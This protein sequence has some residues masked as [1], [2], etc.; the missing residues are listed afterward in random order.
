[1][2][3]GSKQV[4]WEDKFNLFHE[5]TMYAINAYPPLKKHDKPWMSS[6][7]KLHVNIKEANVPCKA[8]TFKM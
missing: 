5:D 6:K 7:L 4:D 2:E 8:R 1:M 3:G